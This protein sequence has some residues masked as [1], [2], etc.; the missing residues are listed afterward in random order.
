MSSFPDWLVIIN[1]N[2]FVYLSNNPV[3]DLGDLPGVDVGAVVGLL[4]GLEA[5]LNLKEK[6]F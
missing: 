5:K 6:Y 1:G 4:A 2:M 3:E